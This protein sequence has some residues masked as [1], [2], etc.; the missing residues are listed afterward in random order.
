MIPSRSALTAVPVAA[1]VASKLAPSTKELAMRQVIQDVTSLNRG[2]EAITPIDQG[3]VIGFKPIPKTFTVTVANT[4]V[5]KNISVFNNATFGAVSG[6]VTVTYSDGRSGLLLNS[7]FQNLNNG[8]G[9]MIYGFNVTGYASGGAK[10]DAVLNSSALE[11][12]YF[13]GYGD[14]YIPQQINVSGSERNTQFKDGLLTVKV[15]ALINCLTQLKMYLGIGESLQFV[16]FTTP[17]AD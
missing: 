6:E 9:L 3:K 5:A 12:R 10:S 14:S 13:N 2:N 4:V 7:L 8:E 17:I 1:S 11:L 15:Q 16:F